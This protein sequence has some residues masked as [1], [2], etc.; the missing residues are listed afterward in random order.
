ME[1][2]VCQAFSPVVSLCKAVVK[3]TERENL[4]FIHCVYNPSNQRSGKNKSG[5]TS[6]LSKVSG[7]LEIQE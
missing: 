3:D 1:L 2:Q 7:K 4:I 5:K 6:D